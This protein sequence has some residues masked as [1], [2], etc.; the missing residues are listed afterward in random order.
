MLPKQHNFTKALPEHLL[1]Q[2]DES[3]KSVYN[4][5]FLGITRP[6]LERELERRLVERV[7]HFMLEL[8]KGFAFIGNQYRL[9]LRDNEYFVDLLFFN[10]I[11]KC[12]VAV[13]LKTVKF[14][15]EFAA[16][17]DLYL[18]LLNEQVKLKDENPAIGI[19]LCAEK[20]SI[21]VEYAFRSVKNPMGVAPYQLTVKPPKELQRLLPSE[22]TMR[23]EINKEIRMRE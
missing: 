9:T 22:K 1:E 2:A 20:D 3:L 21:V 8:G 6:V 5:G 10:R 15:P 11:L 7:R 12:L 17:M 23:D 19:I 14:E 13:E 18:N 16:K 4:L